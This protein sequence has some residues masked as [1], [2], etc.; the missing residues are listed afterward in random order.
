MKKRFF[1]HLTIALTLLISTFVYLT[2]LSG[3]SK[4]PIGKKLALFPYR[5]G[6]WQGSN[7]TLSARELKV[8]GVED[9]MMRSYSNGDGAAIWVYVGY[10]ER[11]TEGDII[12]PPKHCLPASGWSQI[13][14]EKKIVHFTKGSIK[15]VEINKYLVQKGVERELVFYWYQSRGRIVA[16]AYMDR[17]Y[18][19]WDSILKKRSDGALVRVSCF[20][21]PDE[22]RIWQRLE[23]FLQEFFPALQEYL[24]DAQRDRSN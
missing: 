4:T 2:F 13:S 15:S 11:Q 16:N 19:L 7:S 12:H 5:L 23:S 24:P 17:L 9:Y 22:I 18:L 3:V 1:A 14:R 10:Y 8:L 20:V 21:N 6:E